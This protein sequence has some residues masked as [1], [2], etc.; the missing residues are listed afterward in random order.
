MKVLVTRPAEDGA[1]TA[2][3]LKALGHEALLAPL[4]TT[5]FFDS[6]APVLEDVQAILAT[7]ANGVRAFARRSSRRDFPIFAVG[8]Q[9]A[10]A[11][12][13][14][15]FADVR[16]A[17]GNAEALAAA[18][19]G[20]AKPQ[21]GT[22]LHAAGAEAEGR[23][24]SALRAAGF[25]V[26]LEVLYDVPVTEE[27]PAAAHAALQAGEIDARPAVLR[28]RRP[29]LFG[30]HCQSKSATGL[31]PPHRLLHQRSRRPAACRPEFQGDPHR[32]A[33]QPGRAARRPLLAPPYLAA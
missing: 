8:A 30:L 20:W 24:A 32:R 5:H 14:A 12:R 27:L 16:D 22:L 4:L 6:P 29:S 26:R 33:P 3:H 1:D 25:T 9:T 11:A 2:A 10:E 23:L 18:V 21:D 31:R 17:D 15:G 19:R 7:S 13:A 28:P